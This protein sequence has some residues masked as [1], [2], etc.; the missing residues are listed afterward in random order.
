MLRIGL[1]RLRFD[2]GTILLE[3]LDAEWPRVVWDPR[4][5]IHRAPAFRYR[6]LVPR[7]GRSDED[8][9]APAL[10]RA[11]AVRAPDLRPYQEAAVEAW[12]VTGQRGVVVMPP[13]AGKTHVAL[14]AIARHGRSTLVLVPTRPLLGQWIQKL[15]GFAKQPVGMLGDGASR[16]EPLTVCTFDSAYARM[17]RLGADF[18]L[19]VVDEVHQLGARL[20]PEA[21]ELSAAPARLGLTATAPSDIRVR[22][23]L[24]QLV[25]PVVSMHT[26]SG[27]TGSYLAPY[28]RVPIYV[29]LEPAERMR[30][31][32]AHALYVAALEGM[33][34]LG[35]TPG[36]LGRLARCTDD[37]RRGMLG[38]TLARR[39]L[40]MARAKVETTRALLRRH[41]GQRA[42]IFTADNTA[43]YALSRELLVPAL[44]CEIR[45]VEREQILQRLRHGSYGAVIS[46]QVLN[47]GLDLPDCRVGII[48][49]ASR[50]SATEHHQRLGR[51]LRPA[52][53]KRAVLYEL[54]AHGTLE[55]EHARRRV[56]PAAP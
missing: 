30:Y 51:L 31:E 15:E 55:V 22:E 5:G 28:R 54:L 17:D 6:A 48:L 47:E 44:T 39:A 10:G 40:A 4:V 53:G 37:G 14:G 21:L 12:E 3:G 42:L 50:G 49:A 29:E 52:P 27:L 16:V 13:G 19:L 35:H 23:R 38:L 18:G 26:T 36:D 25:G 34:R 11:V 20:R 24:T 2:H 8:Q 46:A 43:A 32:Q 41:A 33:C 1:M 56:E 9:L 45:R 7:L